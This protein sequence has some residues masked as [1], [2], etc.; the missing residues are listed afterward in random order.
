MENSTSPG[1]RLRSLRHERSLSQK[2]LAERAGVSANAISLIENEEI[3]PS[4]ATLQRLAG[5]LSVKMSYFFDSTVEMNVVH[6]R[7]GR[8]PTLASGGVTI[9]GLGSRLRDQICDPFYL[10]L[11][12]HADAGA[13]KVVHSGQ[14][15]VCCIR[16]T[17]EYDVDGTSYVLNQGDFLLFKADLPHFWRNPTEET[18]E[19]LLMLHAHEPREDLARLHFTSHPSVA[20]IG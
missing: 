10:T 3:S 11:A 7:A 19:L 6:A 13:D 15:F 16:G 20:H 8:R 9:E 5:A 12:P 14:E 1:S 2:G 4:V 18:A 17:I